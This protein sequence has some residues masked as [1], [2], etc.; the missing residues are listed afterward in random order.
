MFV[1]GQGGKRVD[2]FLLEH[3]MNK[4]TQL[5][6]WL[7]VLCGSREREGKILARKKQ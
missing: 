6:F 3:E 7:D 5:V 1:Q 4:Q 2:G